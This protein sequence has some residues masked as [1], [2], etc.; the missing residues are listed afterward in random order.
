MGSTNKLMLEIEG[1]PMVARVVD[2]LAH[3]RLDR[4]IVVTG[5]E[6]ERIEHALEGRAV[7]LV[8]NPRYAEGISTS[9]RAGIE[10][11]HNELDGGS[12]RTSSTA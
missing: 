7:E 11:L 10:A 3:T 5:H 6:P 1:M 12:S 9:I 2:A 8:H 4:V